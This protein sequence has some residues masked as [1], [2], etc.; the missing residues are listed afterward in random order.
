MNLQE[1]I[2]IQDRSQILEA[3]ETTKQTHGIPVIEDVLT[4]NVEIKENDEIKN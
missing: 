3:I 4:E 2:A 1:E